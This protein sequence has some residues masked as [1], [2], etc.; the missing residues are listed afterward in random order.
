[1]SIRSVRN[2]GRQMKRNIL[3][4]LFIV[5]V[6]SRTYGQPSSSSFA[7]AFAA[8]GA[9]R[10]DNEVMITDPMSP[11]VVVL[12]Y[13]KGSSES[14]TLLSMTHGRVRTEWR[15]K[16]LPEFMR[17]IAPSNLQV[18][19]TEDGPVIVLHGCAPHL[20]GGKGLAGALTYVIKEH[21]M[22]SA[23]ASWYNSTRTLDVV[24]SPEDPKLRSETQQ[25][26]LDSM[27]RDEG[28]T[29]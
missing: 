19:L 12:Y 14:L 24:Y 13:V 6:A 17:V 28:Y 15:L 23:Y 18:L 29:P 3:A 25:K 2:E 22:Y 16:Q 11:K 10:I 5:L 8:L 20:C 7:Q 9:S 4:I 21:R 27:L 26:L 1:M